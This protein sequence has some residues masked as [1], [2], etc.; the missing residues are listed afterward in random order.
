[1]RSAPAPSVCFCSA[2]WLLEVVVV[3]VPSRRALER[4]PRGVSLAEAGSASGCKRH[5]HSAAWPV[6]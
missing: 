6:L 1:L 3:N 4:L 5:K 2:I